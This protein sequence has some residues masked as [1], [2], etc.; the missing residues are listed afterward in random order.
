M[1]TE[2]GITEPW[3]QSR[4]AL[5]LFRRIVVVQASKFQATSDTYAH[6][7]LLRRF[8]SFKR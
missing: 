3:D 6:A 4:S 5:L 7:L 8:F 1:S 2:N